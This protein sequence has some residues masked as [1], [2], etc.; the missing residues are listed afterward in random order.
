MP[1]LA[2]VLLLVAS[3]ALVAISVVPT[4]TLAKN[5]KCSADGWCQFFCIILRKKIGSGNTP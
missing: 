1:K 3:T 4:S 2:L 5:P